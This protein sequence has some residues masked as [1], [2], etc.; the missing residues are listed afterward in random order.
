MK[1]QD[2]AVERRIDTLV[3]EVQRRVGRPSRGALAVVLASGVLHGG[4]YHWVP[5]EQNS[6]PTTRTQQGLVRYLPSTGPQHTIREASTAD[7]TLTGI[8]VRSDPVIGAAPGAA[9]PVG[10]RVDL[11][12][13]TLSQVEVERV[14]GAA[15]A[16]IVTSAVLGSGF[17][18][19]VVIAAM[20]GSSFGG[21]SGGFGRRPE[22]LSFGSDDAQRSELGAI[23]ATM[24]ALERASIPAFERLACELEAHGAPR[25]LVDRARL[26]AEDEQRH[27]DVV[28]TLA[29]QRGGASRVV[30]VRSV[31]HRTLEAL[32]IENAVEGCVNECWGA[33]V[34]AWQARSAADPAVRAA[35]GPIARDE[36]A[37][38]A[39]ASDIDAWAMT[40]LSADSQ[41]RVTLAR[42]DAVARLRAEWPPDVPAAEADVLGLPSI[43][44][45]LALFDAAQSLLAAG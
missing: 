37:H 5:L 30:N 24:E 17:A 40:Q 36:A 9:T 22:G 42:R 7:G 1:E 32:A 11:R 3:A 26:A 23:L 45:S 8:V 21:F 31:S 12:L 20:P 25:A 27:A 28:A 2:R 44:Q 35:F 39:L 13:A 34:A 15:V 19:L 29:S 10:S 16:G 14:N 38:A 4:C 33:I 43:E 18:T 41:A 6:I